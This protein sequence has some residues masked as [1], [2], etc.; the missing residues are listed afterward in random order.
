MRVVVGWIV[1]GTLLA[2]AALVVVSARN[3]QVSATWMVIS[4]GVAVGLGAFL[5]SVESVTS[6]DRKGQLLAALRP[7][8]SVAAG[9]ATFLSAFPTDC[10]DVAGVRSWERCQTVFG[11]ATFEWPGGS[12]LAL[13][14]G[15]GVGYLVWRLFARMFPSRADQ[16]SGPR[17]G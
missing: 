6:S 13:A 2:F 8:L 1:A 5:R 16:R 7:M 15:P 9:V 17:R 4:I 14:L 12:L 11:T 10:H 3:T